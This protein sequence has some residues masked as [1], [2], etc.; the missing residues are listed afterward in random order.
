MP[1]KKMTIDD[2]RK[3][4]RGVNDNTD[5]SPEFL[6]CGSSSILLRTNTPR[7]TK[8]AI[9]DSIRKREIVMPEEHTGQL[10]FEYAWKE[11]LTR[12][13]QAGKCHIAFM[14]SGFKLM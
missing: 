3:N 10:G 14:F 11:L 6:V 12:S 8:Q 5:F 2:Y 1:Q 4:L 7:P 9:F 13:R